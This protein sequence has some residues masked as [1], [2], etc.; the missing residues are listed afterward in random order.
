MVEPVRNG[1]AGKRSNGSAALDSGFIK[2]RM[3]GSDRFQKAGTGDLDG[4]GRLDYVVKRPDFNVD[5]YQ[6][7]G[8]WK[9]S[10]DTYKIEAYGSD[11]RCRWRHDMGWSIEEGIWYSPYVVYDLDGN[12]KAEVYCKGG[13]GDPRDSTG[14]VTAGP[15][16]LFKLDGGTGRL[17]KKIP[18]IGQL[19]EVG[20]YNYQN[21]NMLAVAYLDG[22]NPHLIVQRGTYRAIVIRAYD[23]KL[24]LVWEWNSHREKEKY[25]SQGMAADILAEHPGQECYAG[26]SKGGTDS[27]CIRPAAGGSATATSSAWRR[28]RFGGTPI[29]RRRSSTATGSSSSGAT[30]FWPCPGTRGAPSS[31]TSS[32]TGARKW[33]SAYPANCVCTRPPSRRRSGD[34]G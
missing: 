16:W 10:Q 22:K 29:R 21:R 12:G 25:D 6:Q 34:P 26:E 24:R 5:P 4:D 14:H 30:R 7:P 9:K 31:A 3:E 33:S 32:A 1:K 8:Y 15:E 19:P 2:I 23:K 13:E 27:G 17:V 20:G 18:W 11:G 28:G